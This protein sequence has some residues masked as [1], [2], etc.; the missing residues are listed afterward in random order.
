VH[1]VRLEHWGRGLAACS[2][3]MVAVHWVEVLVIEASAS[4]SSAVVLG[5][6]VTAST[7]EDADPALVDEPH[8]R[9]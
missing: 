3:E 2:S 5:S 9:F 6:L 1:F 7:R 8:L 4:G